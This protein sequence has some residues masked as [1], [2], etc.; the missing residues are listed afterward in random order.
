MSEKTLLPIDAIVAKV[1]WIRG[2]RAMLDTDLAAL[3]GVR[4]KSLNLAVK[5]NTRRFPEDFMFQLTEDE[6]HCLRFQ[7][8][9]S[10]NGRGGRRYLPFAFTE[11]GI[12]MLSGVLNSP[13][14]IHANIQIM[15]TFTK[16]REM[17]ASNELLRRRIEELEKKY[18][19]H[20][21]QFRVVFDAIKKL[22]ETPK[23]DTKKQIGFH[24]KY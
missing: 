24:V 8:E 21:Q 23:P 15:R 17:L 2:K 13:R 10:K 18:E 4:T 12:A 16:L 11:Q 19:K 5:R 20:D 3:Y 1:Y 14:A 7:N 22:L 9:T 6:V